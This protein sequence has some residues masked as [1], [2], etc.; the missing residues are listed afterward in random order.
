MKYNI[1]ILDENNKMIEIGEDEII[2]IKYRIGIV[3]KNDYA[4]N[5]SITEMD[6]IGKIISN[7]DEK[8][9]QDNLY[10]RNKKNIIELVKWSTSYME[11]TDYRDVEVDIDLGGN[12][13]INYKFT[14]MFVYDFSQELSIE[15]GIGI[16][17]VKLRQKFYEKSKLEIK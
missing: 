4:N 6:M 2:E 8:N 16:F 3:G 17:C 14:N 11:K 1:K 10:I 12:K 13:N 15:K 5:R 7:I 9:M